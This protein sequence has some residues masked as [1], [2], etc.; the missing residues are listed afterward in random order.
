METLIVLVAVSGL[1][2]AASVTVWNAFLVRKLVRSLRQSV[3]SLESYPDIG[4]HHKEKAPDVKET[5]LSQRATEE[6]STTA[7]ALMFACDRLTISGNLTR[8]ESEVL[9]VIARGHCAQRV[10][11]T[12][13]ISKATAK[14]HIQSIYD[15]LAVHSRQGLIELVEESS[16]DA[17]EEKTIQRFIAAELDAAS[18]RV[19]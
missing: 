1:F 3:V 7:D 14:C 15:K 13:C 11:E 4:G 9:E 5:M 8:R 10:A 19:A 6:S 2:I 16:K 18:E 17:V 12:L